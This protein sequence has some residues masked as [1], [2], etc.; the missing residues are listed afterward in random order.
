MIAR[1]FRSV[2]WVAAVG[3]AALGCYMLSLRVASERAELAGLEHRIE[4]TQQQIRSLQT[5]LGTRGRLQQL[6]A[7]N[8]DVLA[9]S[10]PGAGQFVTSG[11]SLARFDTRAPAV[12]DQL[13][14]R[15]A[16]ADAAST[17]RS[18]TTTPAA[19]AARLRLASAAT[20]ADTPLAPQHGMALVHKASLDLGSPA[21]STTA[22]RAARAVTTAS[23]TARPA[24]PLA[25]AEADPL[26]RTVGH[27]PAH[28]GAGR[29][30]PLVDDSTLRAIASQS[31]AERH[32]GTGD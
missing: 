28:A 24:A 2:A 7:W 14:V 17:A 16:S 32:R 1:G 25:L 12:G 3:T 31:H 10:A 15:M 9:L 19:P 13:P 4:T 6:E 26:P 5:E 11:V 18:M 29:A 23:R 21:T 22:S 8:A 30:G 27:S 20:P